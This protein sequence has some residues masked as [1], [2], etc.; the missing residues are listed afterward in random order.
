MKTTTIK[1]VILSAFF[2]IFILKN[3]IAQEK[4][5][6]TTEATQALYL[7]H[8]ELVQKQVDY[9]NMITAKVKQKKMSKS[10]EAVYIIPI[11]FHIIH[12]DG[13]ENISDAQILDQVAILNRDYRK[14][15]ADTSLIVAGFDTI[16]ADI[17]VEFRLAR[18]DH[19]FS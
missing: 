6:G 1:F 13:T 14:L 3:G 19:L 12:T 18:L 11:V 7:L 16:A 9:D 4:H 10:P 2:C 15:N 8:P 5:C 17:K